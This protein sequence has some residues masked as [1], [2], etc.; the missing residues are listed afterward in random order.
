M[1]PDIIMMSCRSCHSFRDAILKQGTRCVICASGDIDNTQGITFLE[2][3]MKK[4]CK[5]GK[6]LQDSWKEAF[7]ESRMGGMVQMGEKAPIQL[8][9]NKES[10]RTKTLKEW[11]D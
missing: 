2:S 6:T 9:C 5:D 1:S 8:K 3:F 7:K 4:F 10:D 11:G